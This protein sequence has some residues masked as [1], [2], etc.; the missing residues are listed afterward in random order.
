MNE[1]NIIKENEELKKENKRLL[2]E[3]GAKTLELNEVKRLLKLENSR[4]WDEINNR[5]ITLPSGKELRLS[6][7]NMEQLEYL[8]SL[9]NE[10]INRM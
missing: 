6:N 10:K 4:L 7:L 5:T 1:N 2:H 8:E 3:L 9:S